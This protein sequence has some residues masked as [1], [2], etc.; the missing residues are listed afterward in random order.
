MKLKKLKG[1]AAGILAAGILAA[2]IPASGAL[3]TEPVASGETVYKNSK[4]VIDASNT[5]DGYVMIK[6]ADG[7][8]ASRL[9][10]IITGPNKVQYTYDLDKNGNYEVFPF[11]EGNGTYS[12]GVYQQNPATGK[13]GALL[14]ENISVS[15]TNEFAPFLSSNQY[16]NFSPSSQ[17]VSK[18][19]E[20]CKDKSGELDKVA[21]VYEFVIT[22]FTY[23]KQ[24]AQTVQSGYIPDVD[25]VLANKKGIC[26]D[27]AAVMTAMLRSQG[28]PTKLVIGYAGSVYHAWISVHCSQSGWVDV[29]E[30]DG[31]SWK[32]MDPTFASSSNS[33]PD[34]MQ[35]IGNGSNYAPKFSY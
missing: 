15:L 17:V 3:Y 20:L 31:T 16:V 21:A 29:I 30:F 28:V 6:Y 34:V 12:I 26:F 32:L 23:D 19:A 7:I 18:A 24:K 1:I 22:G 25:A 11:S 33:S 14:S 8:S 4:A 9:K 35:Y 2:A 10:V 27:Y 5:S 13:Y